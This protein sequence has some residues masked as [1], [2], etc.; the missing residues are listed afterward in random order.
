MPSEESKSTVEIRRDFHR[1]LWIAIGICAVIWV[2]PIKP[3]EPNSLLRLLF[4]IAFFA[5]AIFAISRLLH[6]RERFALRLM[7]DRYGDAPPQIALMAKKVVVREQQVFRSI[8]TVGI[9]VMGCGAIGVLSHWPQ[10]AFIG[11]MRSVASMGFIGGI[12]ALGYLMW[13]GRAGW[14]GL[15]ETRRVLKEM[16]ATADFEP[17]EQADSSDLLQGVPVSAEGGGFRAGGFHW[18]WD[19]FHKNAVVFGQSGTGKTVCVLNA[20]LDGL[21]M[22][23]DDPERAPGGLVLDPKGDFRDKLRGLLRKHGRESDLRVIDPSSL[24]ETVYWNPFDSDDDE[25]ELASRFAAVL[26]VLGTKNTQDTFWIDSA[27]KFMRHAIAL[28]RHTNPPDEPPTFREIGRLAGSL[29]AVTDRLGRLP[30]EDADA[31]FEA[32]L[33]FFEEWAGMGEKT[34]SSVQ[35]QLTNMIDPFLMQPYKTVFGGRSTERI[36]EMLDR[37]RILYVYMPIA[38]KE[39]MSRTACTLLKLEFFR[40]V[41]KRVDKKRE[42]FFLC[43]EFQVYLTA[44]AGKGDSD[45]FERSRQSRHANVIACQNIPALL[46]QTSEEKSVTNLLGNCAV[47]LFLRNTDAETNE[48]AS[49]LFGQRL[50]ETAAVSVQHGGDRKTRGQSSTSMSVDYDYVVRPEAFTRL[51]IP[52]RGDQAFCESIVH[53]GSRSKV[54][55]KKLKWPVHPL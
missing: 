13:S 38:D 34:R 27:K 9:V 40:E 39:A 10:F 31:D 47:K 1:P 33:D 51:G 28:I 25:L 3:N 35:A 55:L 52:V 6:P 5:S 42:S 41:L 54:E 8:A 50:A 4:T 7:N 46:K 18:E 23:I 16:A 20:L 19:D 30:V 22:S 36:G 17:G 45:F 2:A 32:C 49:N 24:D 43:D 21:L 29:Q 14:G 37:G 11:P 15:V 12:I 53:L 48:Y 44:G 26:E